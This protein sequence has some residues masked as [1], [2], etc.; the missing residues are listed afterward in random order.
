MGKNSQI[1]DEYIENQKLYDEFTKKMENL[2]RDLLHETLFT[3]YSITSR[4]KSTESLEE[5]IGKT[6]KYTKLG[7]ITDIS[8]IR[9]I[10]F[11]SDD[12]DAIAKI[13]EDNFTVDPEKSI[14]KRK[15]LDPE[16]F[17]YLSL[18]YVVS[19][20]E[21][22]TNLLEYKRFK[23]LFCE[24]QIRSILQHAWAE[25]EHDFGYKSSTG[26]PKEIRRTFSLQAGLLEL[27][28]QQFV[29]I[30]KDIEEYTT[31]I[32]TEISTSYE[33]ISIDRISLFNYFKKSYIIE[34]IESKIWGN[35]HNKN[36]DERLTDDI[37]DICEYFNIITIKQLDTII[38][39]NETILIKFIKKFL[40]KDADSLGLGHS[41][42]FLGYILAAKNREYEEILE[43]V[44]FAEIYSSDELEQD[45]TVDH[46]L[47]TLDKI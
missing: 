30:K 46:V 17:G 27:A 47:E 31:K 38:K 29:K 8:G 32:E 25:I 44:R 2:T 15:I 1:I 43:Y 33:N 41:I 36:L 10:C 28:D 34:R 11:F 13:I 37:V 12:I 45:R 16:R 7:D 3:T 5:K 9:I 35:E 22:R 19:L 21:E 24:I 18:H 6:E 4:L 39:D 26:I 42:W 14:D 40:S 20:P 23:G